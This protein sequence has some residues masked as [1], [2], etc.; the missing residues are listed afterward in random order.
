MD[1]TQVPSPANRRPP[2]AGIGRKKGVPNKITR[3]VREVLRLAIDGCS[4]D[5]AAALKQ[6]IT[7]DPAQ[8][9]RCYAMLA[10]FVI[11][12]LGRTEVIGD[13]GGPVQINIRKY[14]PDA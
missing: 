12:K 8:G 13:G 1:S 2:A 6:L 11:P 10:E 14:A 3:E 4:D 9:L 7:D 5:V